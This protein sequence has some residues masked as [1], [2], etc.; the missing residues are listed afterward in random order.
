MQKTDANNTAM[1]IFFV[2]TAVVIIGGLALVPTM[3]QSASANHGPIHGKVT[4]CHLPPGNPENDQTV[5]TGAPAIT[6]GGHVRE[7][8][9]YIG[10]C[11][12]VRP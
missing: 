4:Y 5:T 7:H 3:M 10:A 8:G 2:A 1:A 9:D 11:Q 6:Q 12:P